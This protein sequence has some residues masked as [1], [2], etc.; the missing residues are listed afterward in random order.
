VP[1]PL[2]V[3][4]ELKS[5]RWYQ[6]QT[7]RVVPLPS[8]PPAYAEPAAPVPAPIRRW[9]EA[10]G[11]ARLYSHQAEALDRC[12]AG[13]NLVITTGT[14][15][16]KTL[17]FNLPVFESLFADPRAT[18]LYLYPMKAVTQ[19]QLKVLQSLERTTGARIRPAVYDGDTPP[20]KRRQARARSRIILSNPYE[21]HQVLPYHYQWVPFL[22]NLRWVVIDEAHRYRGVFGSGVAQLIRRFRRIL[23]LYRARPRFILASASVANPVELAHRLTGEPAAHVGTDGSPHGRGWLVLW[24]PAAAPDVSPNAQV[25]ELVAHF[26]GAGFQTVCFVPSR[27]LAEV[28][29]RGVRTGSP[30]AA[31]SPYRAGYQPEDRRRIESDLSSGA[32]RGVVS[33]TALELGIDVGGLDCIIIHGWPGSLASFWQQ[34]GRAGRKLQDS[35]V[36]FVGSTDALNQYLL[37]N[38]ELILRRDF[39]SAVIDLANPHILRGHLLCAASESPLKP[40]EIERGYPLDAANPRAPESSSPSLLP[41]IVGELESERLITST[42][43]GWVYSGRD[44]PQEKVA[45]N[46]IEDGTVQVICAG[47]VIETVDRARAWR[48]LY[49]GAVTIN[50]GET[51]LVRSLDFAAGRAELERADVDYYTQAVRSSDLRPLDAVR[52]HPVAPGVSL[53]LGRVQATERCTGFQVRRFDRVLSTHPLE[54]EPLQFPTVGLWLDFDPELA[55]DLEAQG[56]DFTGGFHGAEHALIGMAPLVAMCD[57]RDLGGGS[58]RLFPPTRRPTIVIYDGFRDG[59]GIAEKLHAEFDRLART[60]LDLVRRCPCDDGCPACVLSPR[61]GDQNQ[62]MDKRAARRIL[63]LVAGPAAG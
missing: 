19:D 20:E 36:I 15:S 54:L 51:Y 56:I 60:T 4:D 25:R 59:I 52:S 26:T 44:R 45:L 7:C 55:L 42:P 9:L 40:D 57:P 37:R 31:V 2:R 14:A 8:R 21:L 38:P 29:S 16:G 27:R 50:Q 13:E 53:G 35:V 28:I 6:N 5:R 23:R 39:E 1:D 11:I 12:R 41:S 24:N 63:E 34:A 47:R 30:G 58:Y 49:P 32:L 18:A 61:C 48:E 46:A 3:L 62:P 22:A 10:E 33:T 43:A 17:A